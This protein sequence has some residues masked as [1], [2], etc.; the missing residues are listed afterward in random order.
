[1]NPTRLRML[2]F[3]PLASGALVASCASSNA[4][5]VSHTGDDGHHGSQ[6]D[7]FDRSFD[8]PEKWAAVFDDPER[9]AWQKPEHVVDELDLEAGM[10]VADVGA[11]TGYFEP[12]LS[13]AVGPSG[14][15][16]A[17]DIEPSMIEY[18]RDRFEKEG[19]DNVE[20]RLGSEADPKLDPYS[21]NR[22]LIVN[23]W[24][25]IPSRRTYAERLYDALTAGGRLMVVDYTSDSPTGPPR[26]H[27]IP[28]ERIVETLESAGFAAEVLDEGLP[29]QFIVVG[30]KPEA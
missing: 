27:R 22:I 19:L 3:A 8:D 12:Y 14:A 2:I 21:V 10:T 6:G 20:A 7:H 30:H 5:H 29:R 11:G 17:V 16:I 1:M 9:D 26:H 15:V 4:N 24:H 28:P 23:T 13:R 25:H 18:M